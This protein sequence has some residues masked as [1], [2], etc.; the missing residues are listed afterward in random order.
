VKE[1]RCV[2]FFGDIQQRSV[3]AKWVNQS[4]CPYFYFYVCV[5][6]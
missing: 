2:S 6:V 3:T 4:K 1:L 5:N